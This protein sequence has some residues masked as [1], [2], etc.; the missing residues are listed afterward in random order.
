MIEGNYSHCD[1]YAGSV[2]VDIDRLIDALCQYLGTEVLELATAHNGYKH[3]AQ[4]VADNIV[5]ATISWGG[6]NPRPFVQSTGGVSENVMNVL[7]RLPWPH[8]VSR[9]DS[10]IDFFGGT[11]F[12]TLV[13]IIL[14]I[15]DSHSFVGTV[16]K[17]SQVGDWIHGQA[18]TLYVGSRTSRCFVRVYEKTAERRAKGDTNVPDDWVRVELEYKPLNKVGK[19]ELST[20]TPDACWGASGWTRAVYARICSLENVSPLTA[21]LPKKSKLAKAVTALFR[22]YGNTLNT[23]REHKPDD[24]AFCAWLLRA[25]DCVDSQEF[26]GI[27]CDLQ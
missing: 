23:V 21:P 27:L 24:A 17:I 14:G 15:L 18:R 13:S 10:A 19:R 6:V 2:D 20:L 16:P 26:E 8:T 7:R 1:W 25:L 11:S 5:Y 3:A 4:L 9:M 12:D 22:Q